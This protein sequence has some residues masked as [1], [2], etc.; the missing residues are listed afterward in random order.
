[1]AI[2]FKGLQATASSY[3]VGSSIPLDQRLVVSSYSDLFNESTFLFVNKQNNVTDTQTAYLGMVVAVVEDADTSKNGLYLL[4]ATP[5][6]V[7]SNWIKVGSDGTSSDVTSLMIETTTD[8]LYSMVVNKTLIPGMKYRITD[9]DLKVD[10][11]IQYNKDMICG[12]LSI[13]K[14]MSKFDIIATAATTSNLFADVELCDKTETSGIYIGWKAKYD[15]IGNAQPSSP[16]MKTYDYIEPTAKGVI[17]YMED[18]FGNSADYDFDNLLY[19]TIQ[20]NEVSDNI[21]TYHYT[22]SVNKIN[23]TEE[24]VNLLTTNTPEHQ[25]VSNVKIKSISKYQLPFVFFKYDMTDVSESE[26]LFGTHTVLKNIN[27]SY[28]EGVVFR[29]IILRNTSITNSISVAYAI[30][31]LVDK[32]VATTRSMLQYMSIFDNL[33]IDGCKY[34]GAVSYS[35]DISNLIFTNTHDDG[36][37]SIIP[38]YINNINIESYHGGSG[39][40]RPFPPLNGLCTMMSRIIKE[41]LSNANIIATEDDVYLSAIRNINISTCKYA[42]R[43]FNDSDEI[44]KS[45][46]TSNDKKVYKMIKT[47]IKNL[48][49]TIF[50]L[51]NYCLEMPQFQSTATSVVELGL[52]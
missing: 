37:S 48:T 47:S 44:Y 46:T 41:G 36:T 15:I 17:Y 25:V 27:I 51:N 45:L 32:N 49:Y 43:I 10:T 3:R 7:E 22:F 39:V 33:K 1:M 50:N 14:A 2:K 9:Y 16:G 40:N 13:N 29:N 23:S 42:S 8:E 52:N 18:N 28:S 31:P 38:L 30:S 11:S 19:R 21:N 34:L 6:T 12:R 4:T 35:G 24:I 20:Q 26:T 5:S